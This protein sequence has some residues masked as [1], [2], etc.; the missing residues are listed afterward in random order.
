MLVITAFLYIRFVVKKSVFFLC[1]ER[2]YEKINYQTREASVKAN[3]RI[4]IEDME[5][6]ISQLRLCKNPFNCPHGRPV[7]IEFT[8]YELE[9][10]FKRSI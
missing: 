10:M 8:I 9:K 3:T 4:T 1:V 6:L 2:D 7:I 5:S